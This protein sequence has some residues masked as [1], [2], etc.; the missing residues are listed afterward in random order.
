MEEIQKPNGY[1]NL[2]R[3]KE[4]ALKFTTRSEWEKGEVS[5]YSIARKNKWLDEC[6]GHMEE[7]Q[8]PNGYWNLDKCKESALKFTTRTEWM[9]GEGSA[10]N[11]AR[12]NKWLDECCGH[13]EEIRKPNGY[14]NLDKCKESAL[15]FTT[16]KAWEKGE[17]G[18][19][20]IARK[21]KWLDECCGHMTKRNA[22]AISV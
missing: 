15:K 17:G 14:W 3:C 19:C 22:S 6:C 20:C 13:M 7:I 21:N 1:W 11:V 5:A 16:R 10:Y 4:N 2:D 9:K 8:K 18:A 12:K